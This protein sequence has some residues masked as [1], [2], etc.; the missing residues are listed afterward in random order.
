MKIWELIKQWTYCSNCMWCI[1]KHQNH[2]RQTDSL[3]LWSVVHLSFLK[4]YQLFKTV[5]WFLCIHCCDALHVFCCTFLPLQLTVSLEEMMKVKSNEVSYSMSRNSLQM[6]PLILITLVQFGALE[7]WVISNLVMFYYSFTLGAFYR[8]KHVNYEQ[9]I[10]G[11][12][13][14]SVT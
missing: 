7:A 8:V 5:L 1:I 12:V 6:G 4:H 9:L 13:L 11:L 3:L 10:C 2:P 14:I